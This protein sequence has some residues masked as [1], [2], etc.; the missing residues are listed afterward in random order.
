MTVEELIQDCDD[1]PTLPEVYRR[2]K[3]VI[4][5]PKASMVDLARAMSV[6]SSMTARVLKLVNSSFYSLNGKVETVS[7][8]A[9]ILG[10]QP[11]HDLVLATAVATSFSKVSPSL[12]DMKAYWHQSVERGLLARA[13]ANTC[14]LVDSERLFVGGLLSD[15]GHLVMFQKIPDLAEQVL[16]QARTERTLRPTLEQELIGFDAAQVGAALLA[17]WQ[18]PVSYQHAIRYHMDPAKSSESSLETQILHVAGV[19]TECQLLEISRDN[20]RQWMM[21][22]AKE[23]QELTDEDIDRLLEIVQEGLHVMLEMISPTMEHAA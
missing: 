23:L 18:L 2:V 15:I 9:S 8:A 3:D 6:D 1:L 19:L 17:E 11:L 5:D 14:N 10:M 21:I 22:E 12:M 13:L 4:E 20:W 7:R 16:H